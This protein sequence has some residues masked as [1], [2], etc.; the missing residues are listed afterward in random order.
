MQ[1]AAKD[2]LRAKDRRLQTHAYLSEQRSREIRIA[3]VF[4]EEVLLSLP[5][6]TLTSRLI[7]GSCRP[8]LLVDV[9][10]RPRLSAHRQR[11]SGGS[12]AAAPSRYRASCEAV[13][14]AA[15]RK[16]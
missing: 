3:A 8:W 1:D 11:P 10:R 13:S 5:S 9:A 2:L 4:E 6:P 7:C 14:L 15:G 12:R 16:S